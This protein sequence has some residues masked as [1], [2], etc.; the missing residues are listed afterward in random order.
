LWHPC[1]TG[2]P[3]DLAKEGYSDPNSDANSDAENYRGGT[4]NQMMTLRIYGFALTAFNG[5]VLAIALRTLWNAER[6]L[7]A[8]GVY[9][10]VALNLKTRMF[11]WG[12]ALASLAGIALVV[13]SYR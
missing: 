3:L 11:L 5:V 2:S 6:R 8:Q 10:P 13:W 7:A 4:E 9:Q 12:C 1:C